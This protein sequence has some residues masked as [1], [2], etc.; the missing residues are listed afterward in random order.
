MKENN[1]LLQLREGKTLTFWQQILL[2]VQ[3]SLPAIAGQISQVA[4]EY[5]DSS[6]VGQLGAEGSAAIGLVASTTWLGGGLLS[7][8]AVG[9]SVQSA[10]YIGAGQNKKAREIAHEGFI[11]CLIWSFLIALIGIL[12]SGPLPVL[13]GGSP[14]VTEPATWYLRICIAAAPIM[15]MVFFSG[16]MLNSSG[17][18]LIPSILQVGM[19]GLDVVFNYFWIFRMGMGVPGAA[20][21]T[22]CA[23]A[24][25]AVLLV[26]YLFYRSPI[27]K[28]HPD[29]KYTIHIED[30]KKAA[31]I[32][33]PIGIEQTIQCGA[34]I[35]STAIVAPLGTT[36][37]AANSLAVTAEGLCYMP[38][39]GIQTAASTLVGQ[40]IG[41]G[42][43]KMVRRLSFL[44]TF[45]GMLVMALSG[46][47]M[48]AFAPFMIGIMTTSGEVQALGASVLRIEAFAEPMFAASIVAGGCF[49]GAGDTLM[50][51]IMGLVSMWCVRLP[52][53]FVLSTHIGLTGVWI[54]MALELSFR[55]MIFLLRLS[56]KGWM[57]RVSE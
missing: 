46:A 3:L 52:L 28:K 42:R 25:A 19:C 51:S 21:G 44:A 45:F 38:G 48:Y 4:M 2:I 39:Y 29:E 43:Q 56:R 26:Y 22:V 34:Q 15:E 40:S 27:L 24:V 8:A 32:G 36:A 50:P 57:H 33:V 1:L 16:D 11:V 49:R 14:D 53:A 55:G 13:L 10:Q 23:Q 17:N 47:L 37:I 18:I 41:A 35:V 20:L 12:I 5:I 6:M 31:K 7:A 9:F 54:A 30:L